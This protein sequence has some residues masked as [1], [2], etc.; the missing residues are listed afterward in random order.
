MRKGHARREGGRLVEYRPGDEL[1][2]SERELSVFSDRLER[3]Q[4]KSGRAKK[5][6]L[7]VSE[8]A[9]NHAE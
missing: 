2:V 5:P 3:V 4:S 9:P 6:T 8:D 1:D 7:E